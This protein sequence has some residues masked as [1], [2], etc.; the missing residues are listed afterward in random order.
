MIDQ[1]Q[2]ILETKRGKLIAF[3]FSPTTLSSMGS[4]QLLGTGNMAAT[5]RQAEPGSQLRS[6][7]DLE[8]K[9]GVQL[10]GL[11]NCE[12]K[13]NSIAKTVILPTTA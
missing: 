2:H 9:E 11:Q 5:R 7:N 3:G 1:I 10:D 12:R 6:D 13:N 4:N 8:Q